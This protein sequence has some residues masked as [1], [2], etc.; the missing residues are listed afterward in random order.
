[1]WPLNTDDC[2]MKVWLY[3][4]DLICTV[5]IENAVNIVSIKII[6]KLM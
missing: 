3:T 4:L 6:I 1:M 5:Q 2:L